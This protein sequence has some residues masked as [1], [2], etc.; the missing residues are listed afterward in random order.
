VF[1]NQGVEHLDRLFLAQFEETRDGLVYRRYQKGAPIPLTASERDQLI[2]Q[3]RRR[4]R[5][6]TWGFSAFVAMWLVGF[7]VFAFKAQ[8]SPSFPLILPQMAV[9]LAGFLLVQR[10]MW[11][12]P[13]RYLRGR[14]PIGAERSREE[15]KR[16]ALAK[17]TW[18]QIAGVAASVIFPLIQID[19]TRPLLAGEN[20][21]WL[22]FAAFLVGAAAITALRKLRMS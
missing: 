14:A 21:F 15:M 5:Y 2:A 22:G 16:I 8:L 3:Y 17:L 7:T 9:L 1:R 19:R 4:F 11:D 20:L 10:W 13:T 18:T 12:G 6:L